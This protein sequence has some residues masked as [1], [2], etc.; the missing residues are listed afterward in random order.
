MW[1]ELKNFSI[2]FPGPWCLGGDF[3]TVLFCNEKI[4]GAP[5]N[6]ASCSAFFECI[7]ECHLLDLDFDGPS[8]TWK[9]GQL[10]E[11]LDRV[12]RNAACQELFPEASVTHLPLPPSDHCGLW[13]RTSMARKRKGYFK[14]LVP[15]LDH[16]KFKTRMVNSWH[17]SMTWSHNISNTSHNLRVWN[18]EVFGNIFK[19]KHRIIKRLEGINRVLMEKSIERL[20]S[21]IN[22]LWQEYNSIV[23]YEEA[24]WFQHAKSKWINLG[25]LNTRFFHSFAIFRRRKNRI[26]ALQDAAGN[27]LYD[28]YD[29]RELVLNFYKDL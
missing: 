26:T 15:W 25:D 9:H 22:Q 12:L 8:F 10:L 23:K 29:L 21:L 14:F 1:E 24:Y 13:V 18:K 27:W 2:N 7:N 17:N 5:A 11:R 19:R 16:P 20:F 3:N 28:D 4:G 6:Q